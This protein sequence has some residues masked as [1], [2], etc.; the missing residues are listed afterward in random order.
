MTLELLNRF[1][2]GALILIVVGGTTALALAATVLVRLK[3]PN[4]ADSDFENLTG[5][6]RGEVFAL[7]YTIVLALV[8]ADQS[9]SMADASSTVSAES[10]ALAELAVAYEAFPA[11]AHADIA[12]ALSEYVHAVVEDE[13]PAMRNGEASLRAAAALEALHAEYRGFEPTT[14]VEKAYYARS[15]DDLG[16]IIRERR[17]RLQQSQEGLSPLLRT[18]LV[19]GA[20]V[21]IFLAYP[22][23]VRS[24]PIQMLIVA[25]TAAFV[26][27]AYLLTMVLDY[28]FAGEVSV[29]NSPYRMGVLAQFWAV[30]EE[31]RPL[32]SGAF[33]KLEPDDMIGNWNSDN[34]F[35]ELL[36]RRVGDQIHGVYR[37]DSGTVTGVVSPD[38]VFRGWWCSEPDRQAPDNAGEVEW[39]LLETGSEEQRLDGRW[40]YGAEGEMRGGWDLTRI[41]GREPS[42]L[43]EMFDDPSLFCSP[44]AAAAPTPFP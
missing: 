3:W 38:G 23:S 18:L 7:L 12:D 8:I 5:I 20:I 4:L 41:G 33:E 44:P 14:E 10:S 39:R 31:P 40:R 25:A 30:D 16:E 2:T 28:P 21:F 17:S 13:W 37:L 27:F 32:Q 43:D 9:G 11:A 19:V 22:A 24:L 1:S 36:F 15:V 42:D 6:L 34:A 35:G 26:S 29:D